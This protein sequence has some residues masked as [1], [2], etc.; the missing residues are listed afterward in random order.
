[1]I[2]LYELKTYLADD[3]TGTIRKLG[4]NLPEI[5]GLDKPTEAILRTAWE[6]AFDSISTIVKIT[7]GPRIKIELGE[8]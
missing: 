7:A 2:T 8:L 3:L 6:Q 5:D 1:M 4:R